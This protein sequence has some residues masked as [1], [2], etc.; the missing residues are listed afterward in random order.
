[1]VNSSTTPGTTDKKDL[2]EEL[3]NSGRGFFQEPDEHISMT[4]G[5]TLD[6]S[7]CLAPCAISQAD[8]EDSCSLREDTGDLYEVI[9]AHFAPKGTTTKQLVGRDDKVNEE[10]RESTNMH[11]A[12]TPEIHKTEY[13]EIV[14]AHKV[15]EI[16]PSRPTRESDN[17]ILREDFAGNLSF[18][19]NLRDV[20]KGLSLHTQ[21][22]LLER[23]KAS[24]PSARLLAQSQQRDKRTPS[25]SPSPRRSPD[26]SPSSPR[27]A[28][29]HYVNLDFPL[30]ESDRESRRSSLSSTGEKSLS[31]L[32]GEV[33]FPEYENVKIID[34][35]ARKPNSSRPVDILYSDLDFKQDASSLVK[36]ASSPGTIS[37]FMERS[38]TL[39]P[40]ASPRLPSR[41]HPSIRPKSICLQFPARSS[42]SGPVGTFM[43]RYVGKAT[44]Q[45]SS[46][47]SLEAAVDDIT[48]STKADQCVSVIVEIDSDKMRFSTNREPWE[49][50]ASFKL[51]DI[52]C[53]KVCEH[54]RTLF[55]VLEGAPGKEATCYVLRCPDAD[56]IY[57]LLEENFRAA[58]KVGSSFVSF[59]FC[60]YW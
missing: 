54:D 25:P 24:T 10:L 1:M 16:T 40:S 57:K 48:A 9:P 19:P 4:T 58:P 28:M 39:C 27:S 35:D 51:E 43:A 49:L 33:A 22:R 38:K 14:V 29:P 15:T 60:F 36:C 56:A 23:D 46:E 12:S 11:L 17:P 45:R 34:G 42:N 20:R 47:K 32:E 59:L 6:E 50:I 13:A 18:L 44:V 26:Q 8:H 55:G 7:I 52:G 41:D 37:K 2:F 3:H 30:I 53:A 5:G 31:S 21:Q